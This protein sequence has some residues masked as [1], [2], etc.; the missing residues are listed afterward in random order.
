MT[1]PPETLDKILERMSMYYEGLRTLITCA[2]VATWWTGP[3]QRRLFSS[4]EIDDENYQRWTDGVVHSGPKSHLLEYFYSLLHCRGY[5]GIR[6]RMRDLP[7]G[8]AEYLS[9]L[10]NL[11]SLTLSEIRVEHI[12]E[13]G[14]HTCFSAFHETLK[15]LTLENFVTSFSA[16]VTLVDY[17]PN[18]TTLQLRSLTPEPDEGLVPSLS[19]PFRGKVLIRHYQSNFVDF[20]DRFAELDLE[21]EELVITSPP[22]ADTEFAESALQISPSTVKFLRFTAELEGR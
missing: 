10:R 8:S 21:Y 3:S 15:Y 4:V 16:F 2:L 22:F 13:E 9:A 7:Q 17:F 18:V 12:S 20:L 6:Y 19:R 5:F 14:F 1:L 11:H